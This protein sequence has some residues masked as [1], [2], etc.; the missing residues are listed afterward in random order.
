MFSKIAINN[1]KRSFKDYTI[2]FLTLT[3]AVCIFYS[4]NS[5]EAQRAILEINKSTASYVTMLNNFIAGASVFVSFILGG[6]IIYANNFL[7]KKRKKEM[8]IYLTLGMSKGRISR[9]LTLE[10]LIIALMSLVVGLIIGV[11]VSQGLS[12]ITARLLV[13]DM[14]GYKF[15]VSFEAIIKTALYFGIIFLLVMAFNQFTI[16]KYKLID[17]ISA[18]KKN[19]TVR[20]KNTFASV[21]LFLISIGMLVAAYIIILKAGLNTDDF[22]ILVSIALGAFGTLLFFFSLSSFFIQAVQKNKKLYLKNL[23]VFVLRQINNKITTNFVSMTVICLMLFLTITLLVTMFGYKGTL[24]KSIEGNIS[25]D[26]SARLYITSDEQKVKDMEEFLDKI[27][28]KL[29]DYEDHVFFNEYD[30]SATLDDLINKYL[31][32]KEKKTFKNQYTD[33]P[34]SAIKLSEYNSI[35][36]LKG[37]APVELEDDE[38]LVVSNYGEVDISYEKLLKKGNNLEV[39]GRVYTIKNE[40]PIE[41]NIVTSPSA[42][43]FL[44]FIVPDSFQG[45]LIPEKSNINVMFDDSNQEESEEKFSSLF[46]RL[47]DDVYFEGDLTPVTGYTVEQTQASI[48]GSSAILVFVG[49]YLGIVFLISSAAVL[50]I[51]QLSEA[52]DSIPRYGVLKKIGTPERMINK[53]ILVQ[54]LIYFMI[55]LSLAIIHSI[56]G[57]NLSSELF[58]ASKDSGYVSSTLMIASALVIIY[59]GYFYATYTGFKNIVKNS[60]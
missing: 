10:T 40:Y 51:Q 58:I 46:T 14:T 18:A 16:S 3:F 7:I 26:A 19:E 31:N 44:Y 41:E 32:E 43:Y 25:F 4:F 2:Y 53:A 11:I 21:V 37:Q 59:G 34:L 38:L 15:I 27:D 24:D 13:V 57:I 55:P 52:S 47:A 23:N 12:V 56:V 22:M 42:T 17:L 50:A 39:E 28:F 48:Y 45:E 8:G 36:E 60:N 29:E 54:N 1:V 35:T 20:L 30:M 9:I 49:I 33:S 5:I 6:L